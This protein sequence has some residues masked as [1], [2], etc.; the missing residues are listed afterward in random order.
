[1]KITVFILSFVVCIQIL[2]AQPIELDQAIFAKRRAIFMDKMD[3]NAVAIF[4]CKPV[5]QRNLD[6]NYPYRQESNYYYLSGF[7][8]P[9][10]LLFLDPSAPRHKY[11]MYIREGNQY[12]ELWVGL[13]AGTKGAMRFFGADTAISIENL[14]STLRK[15]IK[16]D[17][18]IYYTFGINEEIDRFMQQ[19]FINKRS[20]ANW[21]IIDPAPILN[22]MRLIKNNGDFEMGLGKAIEISADAHIEVMK[23]IE[24][25]IFEY[26]IQAIFEYVFRK[27]GSPRNGY[28]CIIGS[29][30]NATIL[31]YQKNNRQIQDGDLI[32]MDCAAEYG[33]YSADITR[34]V[35]ANGEF[36]KEQKEIY[37]IVLRAQNAAI[38]MVRPGI[39]LHDIKDKIDSI[40]AESLNRLGLIKDKSETRMFSPHGY[41]HWIGLEVHDVGAYK[42]NNKYVPLAPGMVFTIEPG[43]YF[44]PEVLGKLEKNG[45]T[46]EEKNTYRKKIE[47]YMHMGIR[48]EDNI[49][50]T[51]DGHVNL[52]KSVP[53]EIEKIEQL[54]AEDPEFII[55][56]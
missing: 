49:L 50:V 1:M 38:E 54:M 21:Q 23:A 51:E 31:H 7:E 35:P 13:R 32:L 10:S 43:L 30:P 52:S 47:K 36:T 3:S 5:Y 46:E 27:N 20:S 9:R 39:S 24:P 17:R 25:G 44:R 56:E 14:K 40:F 4:A 6:V 2:S 19:N 42:K 12:S 41:C 34:T 18:S 15:F 16:Y 11:V 26:E 33:Y 37:E 55:P 48:I 22:E 45:Y 29:G 53:R 28:P 8:E